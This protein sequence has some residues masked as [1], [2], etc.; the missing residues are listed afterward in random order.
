MAKFVH[1]QYYFSLHYSSDNSDNT[2]KA[3]YVYF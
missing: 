2:N 1:K 3:A